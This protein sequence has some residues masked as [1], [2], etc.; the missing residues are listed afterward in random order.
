VDVGLD[1]F[2]VIEGPDPHEQC[3]AGCGVVFAP[4]TR[5]A[6]AAEKYLVRLAAPRRQHE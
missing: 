3:I 4:E 2:R 5:H 6:I 1:P